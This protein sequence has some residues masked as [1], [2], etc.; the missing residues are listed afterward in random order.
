MRPQTHDESRRKVRTRTGC[1]QLRQPPICGNRRSMTAS[2]PNLRMRRTRAAAWSR[3]LHRENVLTPAD[4]IWPLFV[5]DGK[6]VEEPIATLPGVSRWSVDGIA[7]RAEEA[8]A[9]GVRTDDSRVGEECVST[10]RPR[11]SPDR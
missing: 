2:Y 1:P 6:A 9:L 11:W 7:A 5:T 3:A 8:A 4:L 10:C